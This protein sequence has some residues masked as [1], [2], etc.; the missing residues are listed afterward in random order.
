MKTKIFVD[1]NAFVA[2]FDKADQYHRKAADYFGS[3]DFDLTELHTSNYIVDETITRIRIQDGHSAAVKFGEHFFASRLFR[4]HYLVPE[5]ENGAF[6]LFRKYADKKL[7]FTDCVS[8][9][10]MKNAGITRS[11]TFDN[12]FAKAGFEIV[13]PV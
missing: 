8:F 3:L 7:S 6:K 11:F 12:D 13:N 4:V 10:L 9:A 5:V 1:T 2:L